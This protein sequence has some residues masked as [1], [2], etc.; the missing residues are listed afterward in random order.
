MPELEQGFEAVEDPHEACDDQGM[1]GVGHPE[2]DA[3]LPCG[4]TQGGDLGAEGG[5]VCNYG[6][7]FT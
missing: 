6:R 7:E 2:L 4:A 1:D 3:D 5:G